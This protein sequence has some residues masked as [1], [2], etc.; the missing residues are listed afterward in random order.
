MQQAR[1]CKHRDFAWLK[2][3]VDDEDLT[4]CVLQVINRAMAN[5]NPVI[6]S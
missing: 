2:V 3:P 6:V 4:H 1:S 5:K